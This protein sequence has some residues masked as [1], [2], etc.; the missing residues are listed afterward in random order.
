MKNVGCSFHIRRECGEICLP[1]ALSREMP[2]T[3]ES[4]TSEMQRGLL[5]TGF[6]MLRMLRPPQQDETDTNQAWATNRCVY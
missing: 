6:G 1:F 2:K 3:D 5:Q 4:I